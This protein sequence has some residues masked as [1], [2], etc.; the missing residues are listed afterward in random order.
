MITECDGCGENVTLDTVDNDGVLIGGEC[1]CGYY[2]TRYM[3][4]QDPMEEIM[5]L[6]EPD[7]WQTQ[8]LG[9]LYR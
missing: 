3:P 2:T 9:G 5:E 6:L 4:G 7:P 8:N 1:S